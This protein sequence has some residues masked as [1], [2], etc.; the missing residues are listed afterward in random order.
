VV[1]GEAGNSWS[2][3]PRLRNGIALQGNTPLPR[4]RNGI[5]LQGNVPSACLR[6][7]T[8]LQ[9]CVRPARGDGLQMLGRSLLKPIPIPAKRIALAS[10]IRSA[11]GSKECRLARRHRCAGVEQCSTKPLLHHATRIP[12]Y[13]PLKGKEH[14][15]SCQALSKDFCLPA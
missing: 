12:C 8:G 2:T 7:G 1:H 6:N 10:A 4:L 3:A 13:A 15:R 14:S 5:A 11:G 9:A